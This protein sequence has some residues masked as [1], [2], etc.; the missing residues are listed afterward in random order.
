MRTKKLVV[1]RLLYFYI[2][3]LEATSTQKLEAR[4]EVEVEVLTII[5]YHYYHYYYQLL[6]ISMKYEVVISIIN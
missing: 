2:A 6:V 3:T 4:S 5:Y 1:C